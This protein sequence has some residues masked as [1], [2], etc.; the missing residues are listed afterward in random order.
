MEN[1]FIKNLLIESELN[2]R[3]LELAHIDLV[4]KEIGQ[5]EQEIQNTFTQAE[6]EKK[7]IDEWALQRNSKLQDRIE[8]MTKQLEAFMNEQGDTKTI[9]LPNGKLLRRKQPDKIEIIDHEELLKNKN[10]YQLGTIQP[11]KWKPNIPMIKAFIK[12]TTKIPKGVEVV[13]G[14]EKF[15]VKI[16]NHGGNNGSKEVGT[17]A[18][19]TDSV[20][21]T[22]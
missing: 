3:K 20:K 6:E 9:D 5:L 22:V 7:I 13:E 4:L 8:W 12:M 19:R 21:T 18:K 17:K 11:E 15:S 1:D 14:K 16:K 10:L 2:Q